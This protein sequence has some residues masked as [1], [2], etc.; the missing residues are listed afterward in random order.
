MVRA[1]RSQPG[2][3][4]FRAGYSVTDYLVLS[5]ATALIV[6][7]PSLPICRAALHSGIWPAGGGGEH[8]YAR[9][10]PSSCRGV[11]AEGP[12]CI[13]RY[14]AVSIGGFHVPEVG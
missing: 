8:Q 3:G 6:Q 12:V 5:R 11:R 10:L 1:E 4:D 7:S 14:E 2:R 9:Q 13:A